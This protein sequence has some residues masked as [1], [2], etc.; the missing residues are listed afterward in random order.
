MLT[1]PQ[2]TASEP[3]PLVAELIGHGVTDSIARQ[4]VAEYDEDKI[5]QQIEILDW[6]E[7]KKPGKISD[8]AAW[9]VIAIK[10]GHATPK[11]FVSAAERRKHAEAKQARER[12]D[13]EER[14]QKH[15]AAAQARKE[16]ELITGF[17]EGLSKEQIAEH[18]AI[19]IAQATAE[20]LKLIEAG[21][22]KKFGMTIIRQSYA[23]TLLQSQ[24]KLPT[25][26]A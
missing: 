10:N 3:P 26:E 25:V 6:Q 18:E 13:A 1:S 21:P 15:E 9:L 8:P 11:G 2:I 24:G 16:Q 12:S 19:A 20:E 7:A 4:L 5:R 17:W 22:M 14:R 23:R